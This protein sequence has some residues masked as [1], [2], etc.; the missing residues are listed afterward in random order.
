[1]QGQKPAANTAGEKIAD[2]SNRLREFVLTT[3]Y[4]YS[5]RKADFNPYEKPTLF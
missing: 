1:M 2:L 4:L 3:R 5:S